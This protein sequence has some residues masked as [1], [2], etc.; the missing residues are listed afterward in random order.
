MPAMKDISVCYNKRNTN[1][2]LKLGTGETM[3]NLDIKELNFADGRDLVNT[4]ANCSEVGRY[5]SSIKPSITL[6]LVK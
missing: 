2:P 6:S 4:S 5:V 3:P 1:T